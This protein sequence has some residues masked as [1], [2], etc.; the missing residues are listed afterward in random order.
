VQKTFFV[1]EVQLK[2]NL[3]KL[4]KSGLSD[5]SLRKKIQRIGI[6][7]AAWRSLSSAPVMYRL[8][9]TFIIT[10]IINDDAPSA[11]PHQPT[12]S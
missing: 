10:R 5:Y 6:K 12:K 4:K 7:S 11:S 8:C 3:K 2:K 1:D 9:I